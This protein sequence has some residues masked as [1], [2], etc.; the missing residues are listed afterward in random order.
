MKPN[1]KYLLWGNGGNSMKMYLIK[2]KEEFADLKDEVES[3]GKVDHIFSILPRTVVIESMLSLEEL[4]KYDFI[5]KVEEDEKFTA[6]NT[7]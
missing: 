5:A 2:L 3:L 6:F 7:Q 1:E 4:E